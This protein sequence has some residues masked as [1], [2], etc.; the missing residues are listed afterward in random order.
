M[1]KKCWYWGDGHTHSRWSDGIDSLRDMTKHFLEFEEDFHFQTDHMELKVSEGEYMTYDPTNGFPLV[2]P[3]N[4]LEYKEECEQV[5]RKDHVVIPGVELCLIPDSEEQRSRLG[6]CHL[7]LYNPLIEMLPSGDWFTG[8]TLRQILNGLKEKDFI[9]LIA[10][11]NEGFGGWAFLDNA[12]FGGLE[13]KYSIANRELPSEGEIIKCGYWDDLLKRGKHI[14]VSAGSDC[15]QV[16]LWA[17]SAAR[18]VI[19]AE[20]LSSKAILDALI[21]GRSY[22]SAT[23]H[24]DIYLE[25]GYKGQGPGVGGFMRWDK[26]GNGYKDITGALLKVDEIRSKMLEKDYGRTRKKNFPTLD[27]RIEEATI[28]DSITTTSDKLV[29]VD[30]ALSMNLPITSVDLI[31]DGKVVKTIR[32]RTKS[33]RETFHYRISGK[34]RNGYFRLQSKAIDRYGRAEWI[35]SN[36]IYKKNPNLSSKYVFLKNAGVPK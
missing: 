9:V 4:Y 5:S 29:K 27:F 8:K 7:L 10:H 2:H 13:I 35:I 3:D 28:G 21:E 18:N 15:H 24:P 33:I 19:L 1:N 34:K 12:D 32:P 17:G 23:W 26:M 6:Y 36:P 25:L 14:P 11:V 20:E 30:I 22:L 31:E 16:D